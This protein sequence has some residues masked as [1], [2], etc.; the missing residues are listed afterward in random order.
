M[1]T[2]GFANDGVEVGEF[3][4][5][6]VCEVDGSVLSRVEEFGAELV[7]RRNMICQIIEDA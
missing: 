5:I 7:L 4:E 6:V 2:E 3:H 1:C